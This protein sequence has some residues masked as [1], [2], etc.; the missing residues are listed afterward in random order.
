MLEQQN[1]GFLLLQ[2]A[3]D[4]SC[5]YIDETGA[6]LLSHSF[7]GQKT[8]LCDVCSVLRE[9]DFLTLENCIMRSTFTFCCE[10]IPI[11]TKDGRWL[12]FR[13]LPLGKSR[14]SVSVVL[15]TVSL[16]S[17]SVAFLEK[18]LKEKKLDLICNTA[19]SVS[20]ELNVATH[21]MTFSEQFRLLYDVEELTAGEPGKAILKHS[22]ISRDSMAACREAFN[23][24]LSSQPEGSFRIRLRCRLT[25]TYFPS[26]IFWRTVFNDHGKPARVIG[27]LRPANGCKNT[28]G[29][30]SLVSNLQ[31]QLE[32]QDS[33]LRHTS[34]YL[35]EL[36]RYRHDRSNH[37]IALT[38]FLQRGD[39]EGALEYLNGM[40]DALKSEAPIIDTGNP[41][42]DAVI[43]EKLTI[44]KKLG[45]N[46]IHTVGIQP[47]ARI[48][49]M[50]LTIAVGNCLD[51]A[52]EACS[53]VIETGLPAFLELKFVEQR[54]A[55]VFRLRNSSQPLQ[56][57]GETLPETTKKDKANHG[58]GLRNVQRIV[59]KH[60]G[61]LALLPG[62]NEF[63][64]SFTMFLQ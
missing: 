45:V 26:I 39:T 64:T 12:S 22:S 21:R 40:G 5:I 19:R 28:D 2:A 4:T 63:T 36:R 13:I 51:N 24:I 11:R 61:T 55:L 49:T 14:I 25:G 34:E 46:V 53:K 23:E 8:A 35:Q 48:D 27:I 38:A 33:Y 3:Q 15:M 31:L 44:A 50:D 59:K 56:I 20:M 52:V 58:F 16:T 62:T 1:T 57:S 37:I 32:L 7:S 17:E 42:I 41:A 9:K 29:D 10:N 54:G 43:T 47:G 30:A 18:R 60:G 6:E